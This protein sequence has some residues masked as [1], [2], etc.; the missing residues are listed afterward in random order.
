[1][2][3]DVLSSESTLLF[4]QEELSYDLIT[5]VKIFI[6]EYFL[7]PLLVLDYNASRKTKFLHQRENGPRDVLP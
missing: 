7:V 4:I 5:K 3:H 6:H 2:A 1:M